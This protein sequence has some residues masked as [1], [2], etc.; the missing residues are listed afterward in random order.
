MARRY[1]YYCD[2]CEKELE[3]NP[4][5]HIKNGVATIAYVVKKG[6]PVRWG[7]HRITPSC[8]EYQFCNFDCF[9]SWFK[10]L[11]ENGFKDV[12][13]KEVQSE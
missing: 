13:S 11:V 12:E 5:L 2:N 9:A 8:K 6:T 4:H 10:R 7:E 3:N 1:V